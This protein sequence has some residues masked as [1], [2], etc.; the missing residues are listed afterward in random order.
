MICVLS[1]SGITHTTSLMNK[2]YKPKS[3]NR[4]EMYPP[5]TYPGSTYSK[6]YG[7]APKYPTSISQARRG[8]TPLS[9]RISGLDPLDHYTDY[10]PK[11]VE[12]RSP[13]DLTPPREGDAPSSVVDV[14]QQMLQQLSQSSAFQSLLQRN[15]T[16]VSCLYSSPQ[17]FEK[18]TFGLRVLSNPNPRQIFLLCCAGLS[19]SRRSRIS[20]IYRLC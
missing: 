9:Q 11:D 16:I 12:M 1:C 5:Q 4:S 18:F 6:P 8:V 20:R 14:T 17:A 7:K 2:P 10:S 3:Y 15:T 13:H 19:A